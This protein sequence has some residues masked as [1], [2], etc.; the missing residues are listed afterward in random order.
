[1][2]RK[3][4]GENR[5]G[6]LL[7]KTAPL[8]VRPA[9]DE[10]QRTSQGATAPQPT[11]GSADEDEELSGADLDE[12]WAGLASALRSADADFD[13]AGAYVRLS[14]SL[15]A[16]LVAMPLVERAAV[17]KRSDS[18][19]E[20]RNLLLGLMGMGAVCASLAGLAFFGPG[21]ERRMSSEPDVAEKAGSETRTVEPSIGAGDDW[22]DVQWEE[23][24]LALAGEL[25]AERLRIQDPDRGSLG[26]VDQGLRDLEREFARARNDFEDRPGF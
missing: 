3:P 23:R 24:L 26:R 13:A 8:G 10:T 5:N 18:R 7:S 25:H 16:D 15:P 1:M 22:P 11:I 4:Y 9:V 17:S 20:I 6:E 19:H 2:N 12:A 21:L 14:R